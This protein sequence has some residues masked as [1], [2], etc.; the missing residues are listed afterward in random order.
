DYD[1]TNAYTSNSVAR[2]L[3]DIPQGSA[4]TLELRLNSINDAP[5]IKKQLT[6]VLDTTKYHIDTWYDLHTDL[7]NVMEM[8]RWIAYV[9][10]ILI[11]AVASFSIFSALT[12]TVFEKRRDIGLLVALGAEQKNIQK[13]YLYQGLLTGF[14]GTITGCVLGFAVVWAQQEFGFFTLDTSVYIIPALPV[15]L[16][17]T[18]FVAVS[19]GAMLL[20][21][22]ASFMPSRRAAMTKPA[23]ALRWE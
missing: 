1:G 7:Y 15:E 2:D 5:T 8:E 23:E 6:S 3:F 21:T 18:D 20:V 13:I 19:I 9:I 11:V 4:T 16:R 22:F 12:L 17:W 10:L 14:I